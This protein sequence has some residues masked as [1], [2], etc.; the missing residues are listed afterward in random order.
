MPV[1]IENKTINIARGGLFLYS[2]L[3]KAFESPIKRE[4]ML[5]GL[6]IIKYFK[7]Q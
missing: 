5:I 7:I 4:I 6:I 2:Q 3:D 1:N